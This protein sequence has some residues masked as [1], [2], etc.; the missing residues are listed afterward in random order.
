M[1]AIERFTRH[2]TKA[3]PVVSAYVRS[4]VPDFHQAEDL[5]QNVAVVLLR[6]FGEYDDRRPF[7]GWA[8]GIAKNEILSSRRTHAR[9]ALSFNPELLDAVAVGYEEMSTEVSQ[10]ARVLQ[11][12]LDKV[13]GHAWRMLRLR[14][15]KSMKPGEIASKLGVQA[16]NVRVMLSR[17]RTSLQDC[18][19]RSIAAQGGE[20]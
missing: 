2:W 12:C 20:A 5:L 13:D 14:Y 19:E 10:R 8:I 9:G 17:L 11:E 1:R 18:V 15:E 16:G 7:V 6:K 3:Q 4:M